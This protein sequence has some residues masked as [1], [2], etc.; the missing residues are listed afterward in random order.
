MPNKNLIN[1]QSQLKTLKVSE[2]DLSF[3]VLNGKGFFFIRRG[4]N[5]YM[6]TLLQGGKWEQ[7]YQGDLEGLM[8]LVSYYRRK[9]REAVE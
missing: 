9:K 6:L 4:K 1:I 8:V 2:P 5:N 3:K 7:K